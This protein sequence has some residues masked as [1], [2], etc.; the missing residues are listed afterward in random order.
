MP[1]VN[2][3]D[4]RHRVTL[5]Q[6]SESQDEFGAVTLTWADVATLYALVEEQQGTEQ[7]QADTQR[8]GRAGQVTIRYSAALAAMADPSRCRFVYQDT[9]RLNIESVVTDPDRVYHICRF[10][11]RLG[12]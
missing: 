8:P 9:R 7:W 6:P 12:G 3:G 2:A 4:L 1:L 10:R 11:E 5:Q